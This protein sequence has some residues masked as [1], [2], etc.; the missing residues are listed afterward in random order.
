MSCSSNKTLIAISKASGSENYKK[1][2]GATKHF[3]PEVEVIDLNTLDLETAINT[4][5][6]VDGLI[7]S[8]GP[9]VHP[10]RYGKPQ[11]TNRCSIDEKRDTLE[12]ALIQK[13]IDL[14]LPIL[15]ICRGLQILNVA[16]D[17]TLII[18]IPTDKP[19]NIIHQSKNNDGKSIDVNH[20]INIEKSTFLYN[21]TKLDSS[22]VN[23]NHHQG[24]DKISEK[25]KIVAT[26]NDGI[27]EAIE[28]NNLDELFIIAVQWHPER[29]DYNSPMSKE[30]FEYF[31]KRV[32]KNKLNK[33][34]KAQH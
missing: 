28:S 27:I 12:F 20:N 34:I 16:L 30:V 17:G 11:D 4:L 15:G 32:E 21:L 6:E 25:F 3:D 8:G 23:S 18:D 31:L 24:I 13:A 2:I 33:N 29:M 10:D 19:S 5:E 14:K 26:S 7:L 22:E 1:Y 9:D